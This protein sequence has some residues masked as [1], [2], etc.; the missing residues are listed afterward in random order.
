MQEAALIVMAAGLGSRYGGLKQIDPVDSFDRIIIDYSIYDAVLAGFSRVICII[1]PELQEE[2][3]QVIGRRIAPSIRLEY[4][5]Q[6]LDALPEGFAVPEGRTKPWGTAHA[7]LCAKDHVDGP[8]A[9]INAD[10]FYGRTAIQA[11]YD[12]LALERGPREHAMV[13]YLIENTL[14]ENGHVAR[15]IC[16]VDGQGSLQAV[17]ER[18]HVTPRPGGAAFTEDGAHF[19]FVPAGTMVSMN[20][21]GFQK[22]MMGEI[23]SRFAGFLAKKL[24]QDPLKCEYLLPLVPSQL[25]AEGAAKVKVLPT[26]EK[27]YGVTYR[28]DM[29][30]VREA[31]ARMKL[32]GLYPEHL[33]RT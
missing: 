2:F 1:K 13:G 23:E 14:T 17:S 32:E 31:I 24:P 4:A 28:E 5:Y 12:F 3:E 6:C 21:W 8:F 15:G 29:P 19:T 16:E 10:D 26:K 25:I 18:T 33:W 9:V 11:V 22:G 30:R 27:W 20:L 7:V